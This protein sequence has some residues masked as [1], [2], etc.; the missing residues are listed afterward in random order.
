MRIPMVCVLF[1]PVFLSFVNAFSSSE[2]IEP[3]ITAWATQ[4]G[5]CN[6]FYFILFYLFLF[7]LVH[8]N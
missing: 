7:F 5:A 6:L 3:F 1:F 4:D 2:E 8:L